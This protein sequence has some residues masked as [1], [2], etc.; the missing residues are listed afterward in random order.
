MVYY[1]LV[2]IKLYVQCQQ[3]P[4]STRATTWNLLTAL[5]SN[6]KFNDISLESNINL[7]NTRS[8]VHYQ[9]YWYRSQVQYEIY[10]HCK[11]Y[12]G[13]SIKNI[14][15]GQIWILT[16]QVLCLPHAPWKGELAP[17]NFENLDAKWC[18]LV[19]SRLHTNSLLK[20]IFLLCF[21]A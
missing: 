6:M 20:V 2:C 13:L 10:W 19:H 17:E 4:Y 15:T 18:N 8:R 3:I 16:G 14:W 11:Y 12:T 5:E 9:I 21:P 7:T 1:N